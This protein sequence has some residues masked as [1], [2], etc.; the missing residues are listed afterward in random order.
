M[1]RSGGINCEQNCKILGVDGTSSAACPGTIIKSRS[2]NV[3]GTRDSVC[4]K[5]QQG[6]NGSVP[7][8]CRLKHCNCSC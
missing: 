4:A 6:M 2:G 5:L 7:R 1:A 8:G 3:K